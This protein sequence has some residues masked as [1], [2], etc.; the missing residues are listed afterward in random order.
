MTGPLSSDLLTLAQTWRQ[1]G[2][3]V[4]L[5]TVVQ[6]WGSAPRQ[7]GSML[8]IRGDGLFEG[9]VSGG[10]VEGAVIAEARGVMAAG[11]GKLLR[12]GI[13]NETAWSVGLACGGDI[14][15]WVERVQ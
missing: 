3:D 5:A 1:Q 14:E 6:T 12:F 13:S 7:A 10:C 2:H 11:K 4:A 8:I 9:S 15:I